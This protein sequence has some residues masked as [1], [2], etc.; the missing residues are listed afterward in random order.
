MASQPENIAQ[1]AGL[2][3][4]VSPR[5]VTYY[6]F[7]G[8]SQMGKAGSPFNWYVGL[9]DV[10]GEYYFCQELDKLRMIE[11][12]I[13]LVMLST[14]LPF[15]E[16][17]RCTDIDGILYTV[18]FRG[19]EAIPVH[20]TLKRAQQAIQVELARR[21]VTKEDAERNFSIIE[22]R[23]ARQMG[24]ILQPIG[25]IETYGERRSQKRQD[26]K[27][28]L[29]EQMSLLI[30]SVKEGAEVKYGTIIARIRELG[31]QA[32]FDPQTAIAHI[33]SGQYNTPTSSL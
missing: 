4:N 24:E 15:P 6:K 16:L 25:D 9:D 33:L 29:V 19:K 12:D 17:Q 10:V 14:G 31:L 30:S 13:Y 27:N 32:K 2:G 5:E 1:L 22:A 26:V 21:P 20:E 18:G 3:F 28:A 8:S 23:F 11:D 7:K